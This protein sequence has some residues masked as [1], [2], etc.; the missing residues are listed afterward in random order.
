MTD[1]ELAEAIYE[2]QELTRRREAMEKAWV[3]IVIATMELEFIG[4][5]GS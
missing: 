2:M 3:D 4:K 1:R 5:G